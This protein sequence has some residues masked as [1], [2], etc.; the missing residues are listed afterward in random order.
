MN[1]KNQRRWVQFAIALVSLMW[2]T[3]SS[4]LSYKLTRL[5]TLGG[6][7]SQANAMNNLGQ[8]AGSAYTASGAEHAFLY[9]PGTGMLD[10][11][12]L[13]GVSSFAT[14]INDIGQVVGYALTAKGDHHAFL[15]SS[16]TGMQDLGTLGGTYSSASSINNSGQIVGTSIGSGGMRAFLY[17]SASGMQDIGTL[18]GSNSSAT[19]INDI[20]QIFGWSDTPMGSVNHA[21][22]Y[23]AGSGM[24]DITPLNSENSDISFIIDSNSKGQFL[25]YELSGRAFFYTPDS[26]IQYLTLGHPNAIS[27]AYC[28]NRFDQVVGFNASMNNPNDY[29]YVYTAAD[30]ARELDALISGIHNWYSLTPTAINDLGQIAGGGLDSNTS[31]SFAFIL[32]PDTQMAT[33][34]VSAGWNLL[35]TMD[36]IDVVSYFGNATNVVTVWNWIQSSGSWAFYTPSQSDGG[37][38]YA[39]AKGYTLLSTI[40]PGEGFW[41][42]AAMPFSTAMPVVSTPGMSVSLLP[43]LPTGWNLMTLGKSTTPSAFNLSLNS[44][45]LPGQPTPANFSTLWAWNNSLSRWYFAAPSLEAQGGTV[46]SDYI[47]SKGYLDFGATSRTLGAGMGFWVNV[48]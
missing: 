37:A 38:A 36:T 41:V 23:T 2:V 27:W 1:T 34:D 11:G 9:T 13:G 4:A 39:A 43:A 19:R 26:G 3:E 47:K 28:I 5:G 15:Y 12:T 46:L 31:T 18:G 33:V 35:G 14:A 30:G 29:G 22:L 32:T 7:G 6:T 8:V 45:T 42:N 21:F 25:G 16:S 44:I 17:T 24:Q 40:N 48:P 10:L 20:G